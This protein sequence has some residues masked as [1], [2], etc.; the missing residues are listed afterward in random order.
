MWGN[1]VNI[2][3]TTFIIVMLGCSLYHISIYQCEP[4][5]VHKIIKD[6]NFN[7]EESTFVNSATYFSGLKFTFT[8]LKFTLILY[9]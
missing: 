1:Q 9:N 5:C 4:N 6:L 2:F 8:M 7:I 3:T